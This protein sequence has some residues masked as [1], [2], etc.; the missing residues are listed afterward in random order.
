MESHDNYANG[1]KESTYL[2][3]DQIVFGW[4]IVGSRKAGAPLY[5]NRPVGSGGTNA[6]FAE[7][8]QL[9]D[10][11]DDMWKN[12]SVVAVNHFRNAMDG[13]SEYLQNCGSDQNNANKSCLMI[14]RFTK[15]GTANDGVVIANMG[16][17]QSLVGMSTNLDD[18]VYPDEVNGGSITVSGGKITSGTAK[19]NAVSAYYLKAEAKPYVSAEPS[20]ATFS[21]S[22]VD[23]TLRASKAENLKYTTSEGKFGTFK[24]GDVITV[25]SSISVGES[26]TVT[27]TGTSTE[28]GSKLTGKPW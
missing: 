7:Q 23:V 3:N 25:G 10:A 18:G 19:G 14:E 4:A 15:D 9:G 5:F 2:T 22:S 12:K 24:N 6:Q 26:V 8:S 11:G 21:G 17:D 27:V 13:K 16:G 28:D 20:S 1:D